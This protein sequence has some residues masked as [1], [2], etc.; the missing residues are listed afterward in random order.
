MSC[1]FLAPQQSSVSGNADTTCSLLVQYVGIMYVA[2]IPNN[3]PTFVGKYIT[4]ALTAEPHK[5]PR[6]SN[7]LIPA[8]YACT[9]IVSSSGADFPLV[10]SLS[11]S[12]TF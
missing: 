2:P 10:T 7:K 3:N 8:L 1:C 9:S 11:E 6:I 12:E 4:V 5:S